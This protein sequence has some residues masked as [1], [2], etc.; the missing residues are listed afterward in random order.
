MLSGSVSE[1]LWVAPEAIIHKISPIA[2]LHGVVPGDWDMERRHLFKQTAKYRAMVQRYTEG[3]DW[4]ETELFTDA[5]TRRL[6]RDGIVGRS[7]TLAELAEDYRRR[8]DPL[9]EAMKRDGF[10]VRNEAGR[11]YALPSFLIGRN[12]EILIG[13]QGNHRLAIAQV[14]G[15]DRIAG[16]IVCRHPSSPQ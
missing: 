2:D 7:R 6:A 8:F 16:N 3:R 12:G 1:P 9:V 13:N 10:K 5:Y 14:I 15:L 11:D 4:Q